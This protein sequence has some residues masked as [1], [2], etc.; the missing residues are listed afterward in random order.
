[1]D[2]T[3]ASSIKH[4][5]PGT[6]RPTSTT[7]S[8]TD[9]ACVSGTCSCN[10]CCHLHQPNGRATLHKQE[11]RQ[12]HLWIGLTHLGV[13]RARAHAWVLAAREAS[14]WLLIS[15]GGGR[16][17][18]VKI[19]PNTEA[20]SEYKKSWICQIFSPVLF[21]VDRQPF[22]ILILWNKSRYSFNL[23]YLL[24]ISNADTPS[25]PRNRQVLLEG[26]VRSMTCTDA[27]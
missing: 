12:A 2:T 6:Q 21:T 14:I 3:D 10:S 19:S 4:E 11:C 15:V 17:H 13:W 1:M 8:I 23:I 7:A 20:F 9:A 24:L 26:E 18:N 27:F 25:N 5:M 22:F 16:I